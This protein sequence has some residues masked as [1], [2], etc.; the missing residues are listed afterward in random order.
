MRGGKQHN[1]LDLP[2]WAFV[3]LATWV[4]ASGVYYGSYWGRRHIEYEDHPFFRPDPS[5]EE[6]ISTKCNVPVGKR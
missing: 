5:F 1:N 2:R 3:R 4:D 6:A